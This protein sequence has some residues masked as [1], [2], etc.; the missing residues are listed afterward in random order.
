MVSI[1]HI[2]PKR[3]FRL[4]PLHQP[5]ELSV[6]VLVPLKPELLPYQ[7][8]GVVQE[9]TKEGDEWTIR[10]LFTGCR[11]L[12]EVIE[13][14]ESLPASFHVD[15]PFRGLFAC[16]F[17]EVAG[18]AS[19]N[20]RVEGRVSLITPHDSINGVIPYLVLDHRMYPASVP[21]IRG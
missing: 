20:Q 7:G 8:F 1:P 12:H 5:V 18:C 16:W 11:L 19:L 6:Q 4:A 17:G 15:T 13:A 3:K 2:Q 14:Q 9:H 10:E 21:W